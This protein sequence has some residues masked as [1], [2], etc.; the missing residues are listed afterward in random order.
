MSKVTDIRSQLNTLIDTILP[1]YVKLS[2]SYET[3]D[4]ANVILEKGFSIGYG[5]S[6]NTTDEWCQGTIRQRRQFQ[7]ILTNIYTPS[8]DPEYRETLENSLL[9]DEFALIG[10]IERDVT[11]GG[12]AISS[13]FSF[14]NGLEYLIDD[15]KQF[16]IIVITVTI[17]YE[18][19]T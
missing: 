6:E 1:D 7:I 15:R 2:D 19:N 18:E 9:D 16:I 8:L 14:D 5:P 17:D 3:P 4:N 13:R 11:L 12:E 10:A